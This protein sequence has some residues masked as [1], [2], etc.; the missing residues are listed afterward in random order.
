MLLIF[1]YTITAEDDLISM[2]TFLNVAYV[3]RDS[4][5]ATRAY[6]VELRAPFSKMGELRL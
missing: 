6:L 4:P 2:W 3:E 1:D 5:T